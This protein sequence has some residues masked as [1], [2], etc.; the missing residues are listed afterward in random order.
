[1]KSLTQKSHSKRSPFLSHLNYR[2]VISILLSS[3]TIA[4]IESILIQ[5]AQA[6]P[7]RK[8]WCGKIWSIENING[9]LGWI[10]PSTG[11]TNITTGPTTQIP[12]LPGSPGNVSVAATGIHKRSGTIYMFDRGQAATRTT[13]YR[14]GQLYKYQFGVDTSWQA[15]SVSGLVGL[16]DAQPITGA[17]NNLNKMSVDDNVLFITESN[18]IAVYAIPLDNNGNV[19]G[20]ATAQ[21]YTFTGDPVGTPQH[22]SLAS[23]EPIGTEVISGG[24]ITTDEYGDVYNI[25][26]NSI[27]TQVTPQTTSTTK[28][29]F[30]KQDPI[31]KTWIYQGQTTGNAQFAGAIFY[32]GDLYVKAGNQL[33]RVDLTRSGSGYTGWSN[34]LVDVG[35]ASSTS[36]SDLAA[37]GTPVLNLTKTRQIYTDAALTN[38]APDQTKVKTGQYIKYIITAT[39]AGDEW[40]R[41]SN[42]L[43]SLPAG[44]TYIPDSATLN[45]SSMGLA[46]YP[47]SGFVINSIGA[48]SGII[49]FSP[50]PNVATL[51]FGVQVTA[52]SGSITNRASAT[53][54]DSSNIESDPV[55]C[56]ST[57]KVNCA[58]DGPTL[59][60]A[61][62]IS[63]NVFDDGNGSKIQNIGT[64]SGTNAGGLNAVLINSANEVVATATVDN[65]G[66][67]TFGD[68]AGNATYTVQITTDTA[69]VGS[70]PPAVTLPNNWVSTGENLNG[71][72]DATADSKLSVR[73]TSSNVTTANFGIEQRPIAVGGTAAPILNP[74]GTIGVPVPSNLFTTGST[75]S[76]GTVAKYRITAFPS[77]ATALTITISGA[78]YT[79]ATFPPGGVI[80]TL[81][82]LNSIEIDPVDGAVT[83]E[84]PFVAIDNA[85]QESLN[86][87]L[88]RLPFNIAASTPK[89]LLV[90][91][92][93]AINGNTTNNLNDGTVLN[94]FVNGG[95]T[96]D[97][98]NH[99]NWPTSDDTYLPG[100]INA[101][102]VKPADEVEYTIYFLNTDAPSKN[103]K[104]CDIVPDG[105]TF[106]SDAYNAA[107]PHPTEAGALPADT[108]IALG[109][110]KTGLP[111]TPT[112]YLTNI[113]DT[114]T[115]DRGRFYPAGDPNTPAMCKKFDSSGNVTTTGVAA[116]T[117]GA[118][119][120]E[121]V[122]GTD[123]IPASTGAGNPTDSYGFIRFRA[124]VK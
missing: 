43:D 112:F 46:T 65:N 54:I 62:S 31:A 66:N 111:T 104:I 122:K 108:G 48:P 83:V 39:N 17:S 115:G 97:D 2:L 47:T 25:T 80:I 91:R 119:V 37:C 52:T 81:A 77:N 16:G 28:A 64:E 60:L 87:S 53:Y 93:T 88:A 118:V 13:S 33:K 56:S 69:T 55:N 73:L 21:T 72:A 5:P 20:G 9:T 38:L 84:I 94:Q 10:N 79:A 45:G 51:T 85:G 1:M 67:Y 19:T 24:D 35:S 106:V 90:K 49:R 123:T 82:E 75:D 78:S 42:I 27:V 29:Y 3:V 4:G 22:R 100:A 116:N 86:T 14:A 57:P 113:Q 34:R 102:L 18:G 117:S 12:T 110:S 61:L 120:V 32:K 40:S 26:Y 30:Y 105:Q 50:D 44:T 101:G 23:G 8:D 114:A 11:V 36:S 6:A 121:I 59:P 109:F 95:T 103:V 92:I 58:Q 124:K 98:D 63:G 71:I 89:L 7:T 74:G 70:A 107:V 99:L 41:T 96:T 76:D 68:L 15:V